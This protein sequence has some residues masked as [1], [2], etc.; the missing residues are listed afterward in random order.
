MEK[1][2]CR[3][4]LQTGEI[5]LVGP[6]AISE[7]ESEFLLSSQELPLRSLACIPIETSRGRVA[8]LNLGSQQENAFSAADF[9]LM[10]QL[11][12]V[13][14]AAMNNADAF[15]TLHLLNERFRKEKAYLEEELGGGELTELIGES[16]EFQEVRMRAQ[17]VAPA[18]STVILSGEYGVGKERLARAIHRLSDR[19]QRTFVKFD[20]AAIPEERMDCELFGCED[21]DPVAV[22]AIT[23]GRLELADHSTL[24]LEHV[25]ELTPELQHKLLRVLDEHEFQRIGGH[26]PVPIDIR[27]IV[28]TT[29]ELEGLVREGEFLPELYYRLNVFPIRI[30]ALRERRSDIALLAQYF[31]KKYAWRIQRKVPAISSE[32]LSALMDWNWPGNVRELE[33]FM[34]RSVILTRGPELEAPLWELRWAKDQPLRNMLAEAE[35][36]HIIRVLQETDGAISGPEGAAARLR[37]KPAALR[38]KIQRLGISRL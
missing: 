1:S 2:L 11:G 4:A 35:R 38:S 23:T 5:E 13:V 14:S 26:T 7:A 17:A 34:E 29:Q 20:C 16:P 24:F 19:G 18:G 22:D 32:T 27:L 36:D 3:R 33:N 31:V 28:S 21:A 8:T 37:I 25:S 10:Q 15:A 30:P 12:L 9:Y 6:A